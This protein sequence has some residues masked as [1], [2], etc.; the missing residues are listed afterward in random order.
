LREA[1]ERH[2]VTITSLWA[3]FPGR[4]AWT[5]REGPLTIGLV[6]PE[7]R[8]ERVNALKAGTDF[9]ASLDP[10]NL[11]LYGRG[12]P[13]D[14]LDVFGPFV[15]SVHAKDGVDSTRGHEMGE[16]TPLGEGKVDFPALLGRLKGLGYNGALIIEREIHGPQQEADIRRGRAYLAGAVDQVYRGE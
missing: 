1:A 2:Q 4:R 15:R 9:A 3:G 13:V 11:I 14:A 16:E 8:A 6:P 7:T 12:N 5:L 10:A